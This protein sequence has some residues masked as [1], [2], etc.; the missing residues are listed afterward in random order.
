MQV[1]SVRVQIVV[2]VVAAMARCL[3][4]AVTLAVLLPLCSAQTLVGNATQVTNLCD[5]QFCLA[6][7]PASCGGICFLTAA[8]DDTSVST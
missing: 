5:T 2:E 6:D 8:A 4:V 3:W 1:E 7:S